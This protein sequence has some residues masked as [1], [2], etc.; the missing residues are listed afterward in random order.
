MKNKTNIQPALNYFGTAKK[1]AT[2]LDI[3][4]NNVTNWKR[5]GIPVKQAIE[6]AYLANYAFRPYDI[7]AIP[8]LENIR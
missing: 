4:P 3:H 1:I 7:L 6:L 5:D 2:A 8:E